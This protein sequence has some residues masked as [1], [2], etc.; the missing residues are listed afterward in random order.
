MTMTINSAEVAKTSKVDKY[1]SLLL[2]PP[3][4]KL[5]D[6]LLLQDGQRLGE[7]SANFDISQQ[8]IS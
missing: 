2:M 5:L 7:L 8:A 6:R 4:E 1:S 3:G